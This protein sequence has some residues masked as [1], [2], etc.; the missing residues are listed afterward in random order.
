MFIGGIERNE[1][2]FK[3]FS[4][5]VLGIRILVELTAVYGVLS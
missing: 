4:V 5:Y 1:K 3:S 2:R